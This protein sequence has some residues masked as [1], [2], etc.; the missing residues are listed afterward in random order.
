VTLNYADPVTGTNVPL[1]SRTLAGEQ[2]PGHD[3]LAL[4]GTVETDITATK[5]A[6]QSIV[7]ALG[8]FLSTLAGAVTANRVAV[9]LATTPTANLAT[10]ATAPG[11]LDTII[12]AL[13]GYLSTLAGAVTG[14]R[15]AVDLP[16]TPTA[17]LATIATGPAKLDTIITALGSYLSTI[18]G[19]I[20]A[21]RVAVDLA[22]TPTANLASIAADSA[23]TNTKLD[24]LHADLALV[25]VSLPATPTANLATIA[26]GP[27]KLDTIITALG[28]Y[29]STLAGA[30]TAARVAVD[31]ATTPTANLATLAGAITAARMAVNVDS[32]T[33][34][35]LD[36]LH[37]DLAALATNQGVPSG[38][39]IMGYVGGIN[40]TTDT[41]FASKTTV[42]GIVI[43]NLDLV[44]NLLIK[45]AAAP[46]S[47][48]VD[49]VTVLPGRN[50]PFLPCTDPSVFKLRSSSGSTTAAC[51]AGA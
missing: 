24:A 37:T 46:T 15:V 3:V 11:K 33:T 32:V 35:K 50:S 34:G 43:T 21:G 40:T 51:Y 28:S 18:A 9:D 5:T 31:L 4:P 39:A 12:T 38:G 13:G 29:L 30:V 47:T 17:N 1:R 48:D 19:A 7:T 8:S 22:T 27:A 2:V 26:T 23:T 14:S 44:N 16:A 49:T 6:T 42:R 36:T 20:V 25:P 10:L 41:A 45:K